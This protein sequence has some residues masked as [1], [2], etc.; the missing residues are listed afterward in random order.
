MAELN[1]MNI[2]SQQSDDDKLTVIP[3]NGIILF[4]RFVTLSIDRT[5]KHAK[6]FLRVIEEHEKNERRG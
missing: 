2:T 6:P 3:G 5:F 4:P 1:L